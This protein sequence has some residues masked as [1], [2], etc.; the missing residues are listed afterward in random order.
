MAKCTVFVCDSR[1][2]ESVNSKGD[3]ASIFAPLPPS[4]LSGFKLRVGTAID[5]SVVA[6]DQSLNPNF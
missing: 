1:S 2:P 3:K 6:I 4:A 5:R